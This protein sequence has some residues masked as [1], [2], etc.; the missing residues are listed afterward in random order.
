MVSVKIAP[1]II[2]SLSILVPLTICLGCDK[3]ATQLSLG[4]RNALIVAY[5]KIKMLVFVMLAL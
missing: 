1:V 3:K 5:C 2:H 4:K